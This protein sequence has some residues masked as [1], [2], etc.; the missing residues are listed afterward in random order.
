M[1]QTHRFGLWY[2]ANGG[3]DTA[4]TCHCLHVQRSLNVPRSASL[5]CFKKADVAVFM[6]ISSAYGPEVLSSNLYA[7]QACELLFPTQLGKQPTACLG[8]SETPDP[9]T[10]A[11]ENKLYFT[12]NQEQHIFFVN[13][14]KAPS[15]SGSFCYSLAADVD[16][17]LMSKC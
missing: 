13:R 10:T 8:C 2:D 9:S 12:H 15:F 5:A 17:P 6:C 11:T 4:G 14:T 3:W 1:F 7:W 16:R